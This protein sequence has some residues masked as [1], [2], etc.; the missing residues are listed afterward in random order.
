M[1]RVDK[2]SELA[3]NKRQARLADILSAAE[4]LF[5]SRGYHHTS[6]SDVI[7][8]AAISRGTFYL[9]FNSKEALFLKLLDR[10]VNSIMGVVEVV[11]PHSSNPTEQIY[12]NIRRVVDVV[13]DNHHLAV[14]AFRETIGL[15]AEVDRK[16]HA[17]Y[18]FLH[19]MVEGA[20]E[21]GVRVGLIR[22]VNE[23]IVSTAAIGAIK[24]VFYQY[25][26]IDNEPT[27]DRAAVAG[28]L[29]DFCLKGLL[30]EPSTS[31]S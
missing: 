22:A 18:G 15:D 24:E 16:L 13:F 3:E 17:L 1:A 12:E 31:Q 6:I 7:E 21:K 14:L 2:R 11:D 19:E 4:R 29:F 20:L 5:S 25:L 28:A 27:P 9:Y 8:A 10:F 26:V 23:R 30:L